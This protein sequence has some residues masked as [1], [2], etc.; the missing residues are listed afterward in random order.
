MRSFILPLLV[1]GA[2]MLH[3]SAATLPVQPEVESTHS[4]PQPPMAPHPP[5]L[6][7][8]DRER[9]LTDYMIYLYNLNNSLSSVVCGINLLPPEFPLRN[10]PIGDT[11]PGFHFRCYVSD[12]ARPA[13]AVMNALNTPYNWKFRPSVGLLKATVTNPTDFVYGSVLA[14]T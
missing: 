8:A 11:F 1:A 7:L 4:G 10:V 3:C 2:A 14:F 9:V 12:N 5:L 13:T 6:S